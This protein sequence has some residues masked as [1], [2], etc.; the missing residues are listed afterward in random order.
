MGIHKLPDRKP[1][2]LPNGV[3]ALPE[4]VEVEKEEGVEVAAFKLFTISGPP[5]SSPVQRMLQ[6]ECVLFYS[7]YC[8]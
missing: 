1:K 8:V 3:S 7:S 6:I 2:E 4:T 5:S